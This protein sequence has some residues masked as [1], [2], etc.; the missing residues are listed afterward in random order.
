MEI[1]AVRLYIDEHYAEK[2]TLESVAGY[3][4]IDKS[5]LARLFKSQYGITL[6]TYLQQVRITH[7]KRLLRFTE[8]SVEEIGLECGIVELHYFSRVFKKLEGISP[9]EYLKLWKSKSQYCANENQ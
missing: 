5:Y 8:K 6:T 2:L 4:F 1:S 3:F 9:S 7:A